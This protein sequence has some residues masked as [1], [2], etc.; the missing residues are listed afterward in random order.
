[1][2]KRDPIFG[3]GPQAERAARLKKEYGDDLGVLA[4]M[5]VLT[6]KEARAAYLRRNPGAHKEALRKEIAEFNA[7]NNLPPLSEK[8]MQ[9]AI[10]AAI[11]AGG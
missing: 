7:R 11:E 3:T 10:S 1:M 4:A 5:N 9:E 2:T 8:D 6:E